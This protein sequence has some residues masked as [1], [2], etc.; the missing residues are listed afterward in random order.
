ML[1]KKSFTFKFASS[2]ELLV[3]VD[4]K[5]GTPAPDARQRTHPWLVREV[6]IDSTSL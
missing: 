6:E 1:C 4:W 5:L 3:S 2:F